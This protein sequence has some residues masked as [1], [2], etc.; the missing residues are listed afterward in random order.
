MVRYGGVVIINHLFCGNKPNPSVKRTAHRRRRLPQM[1]VPMKFTDFVV[2]LMF[3]TFLPFNEGIIAKSPRWKKLADLIEVGVLKAFTW[4]ANANVTGELEVLERHF[5]RASFVTGMV[6][7]CTFLLKSHPLL[8]WS[9]LVFSFCYFAWFSF[10]WT[11]KHAEAIQ[12]LAPMI[13]YSLVGPWVILVLNYLFPQAGLINAFSQQLAFLPLHPETPF[14]VAL[15]MFLLLVA[16][17]GLYYLFGWLV[18]SPFAYVILAGLKI[19]RA[20]SAFLVHH[21]NRNLLNDIS[22]SVQIFGLVY[23]YWVGRQG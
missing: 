6:F 7:L 2:L 8:L 1:L 17:F 5:K 13:G 16:F 19:S 9:S 12:P 18:F 21:F 11:F 15:T 14:F 10:K 20:A 23:L 3:L 22:V 4:R